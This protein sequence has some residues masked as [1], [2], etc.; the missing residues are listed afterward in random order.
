MAR[1]HI[2]ILAILWW[3]QIW[4]ANRFI[5]ALFLNGVGVALIDTLAVKCK[6]QLIPV[7][8]WS[9]GMV[10]SGS[11]G[12]WCKYISQMHWTLGKTNSALWKLKPVPLFVKNPDQ[13]VDKLRRRQTKLSTRYKET[14]TNRNVNPET[15]TNQML[16][17]R[18]IDKPP[19]ISPE[20]IVYV[21]L[22][23]AVP[24]ELIQFYSFHLHQLIYV[25][26]DVDITSRSNNIV[27][28]LCSMYIEEE[29]WSLKFDYYDFWCYI[30]YGISDT[31]YRFWYL[32]YLCVV[33]Q[34]PS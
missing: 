29:Y 33:A 2:N 12:F 16:T 23:I 1:D 17:N 21:E 5:I 13:N 4:C 15:S 20:F 7:A 31:D 6:P 14:P 19:F 18:N 25:T 3:L 26:T 28:S 10:P 30:I 27:A 22:N 32:L 24:S 9:R 11:H 34:L 8:K